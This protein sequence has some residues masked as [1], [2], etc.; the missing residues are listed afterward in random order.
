MA[1]LDDAIGQMLAMGM[2]EFPAGHPAVGLGRITRYGPKKR[3]WYRLDEVRA[4]S[5]AV[6]VVGAFGLWG[7]ID[8]AKIEVDW[9]GISTAEATKYEVKIQ[10]I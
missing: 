6:V 2:P 9:K 1:S 10:L 5:G 7:K 8:S 4:R 3:A